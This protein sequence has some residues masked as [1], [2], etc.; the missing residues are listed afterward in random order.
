VDL[1]HLESGK[2]FDKSTQIDAG[3]LFGYLEPLAGACDNLVQGEGA[4]FLDLLPDR[5]AG[6]IK[7]V[8]EQGLKIEKYPGPIVE[9]GENGRLQLFDIHQNKIS[10]R[11]AEAQVLRRRSCRSN[12]S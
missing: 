11:T 3:G 4:F 8:I 5:R 9:R 10:P 1:D 12:T 2:V 7:A 6:L